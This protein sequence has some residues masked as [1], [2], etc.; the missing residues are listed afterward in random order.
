[1]KERPGAALSLVSSRIISYDGTHY[2]VRHLEFFNL[3]P[4]Y[5][6]TIFNSAIKKFNSTVFVKL[7]EPFFQP[8][9][10][11]CDEGEDI[12]VILS[13]VRVESYTAIIGVMSYRRKKTDTREY[14]QY[15]VKKG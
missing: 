3:E 12:R 4:V 6:R 14:P 11:E 8:F 13:I 15:F 10:T 7:F 9:W 2:W 5:N 1:M